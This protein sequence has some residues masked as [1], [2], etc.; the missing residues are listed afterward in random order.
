[1]LNKL[2]YRVDVAANGLEAVESI[3]H[4][5]DDL[6]LMDC[7]IPEINGYSDTQLIRK[8]EQAGHNQS[9]TLSEPFSEKSPP[10]PPT[11]NRTPYRLPIIS[12]TANVIQEDRESWLEGA[13]TIF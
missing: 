2:G 8:A 4:A 6:I 11:T 12:L 5:T 10:A 9:E 13:W 1:M 7:Q 3:G